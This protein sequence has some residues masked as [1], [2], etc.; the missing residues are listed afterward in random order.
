[1][2]GVEITHKIDIYCDKEYNYIFIRKQAMDILG[3]ESNTTDNI[4]KL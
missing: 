3:I 4:T 2:N 1:M